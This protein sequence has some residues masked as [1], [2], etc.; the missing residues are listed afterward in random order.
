LVALADV[1]AEIAKAALQAVEDVA[2]HH[3][4]GKALGQR[5]VSGDLSGLYRLKFDLPGVSPQRYR[6]VYELVGHDLVIWGL[7][8]RHS[9]IVYKLI[10]ARRRA[11]EQASETDWS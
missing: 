1:G 11:L 9:H 2:G 3:R 5:N 8:L 7:G 6:L 4:T 10:A